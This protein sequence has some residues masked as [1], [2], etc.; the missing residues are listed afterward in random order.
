MSPKLNSHLSHRASRASLPAGF[1]REKCSCRA[2]TTYLSEDLKDFPSRKRNWN[3]NANPGMRKG[4][5]ITMWCYHIIVLL[6]MSC[7]VSLNTFFTKDVNCE[8]VIQRSA[9]VIFSIFV[10]WSTNQLE[11]FLC[12]LLF[13]GTFDMSRFLTMSD[14]LSMSSS[15]L[16]WKSLFFHALL[17]SVSTTDMSFPGGQPASLRWCPVTGNFGMSQV[18]SSLASSGS[19]RN[20]RVSQAQSRAWSC[21]DFV[22][23][24][25]SLKGLSLPQTLSSLWSKFRWLMTKSPRSLSNPDIFK[26]LCSVIISSV[27]LRR[28]DNSVM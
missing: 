27:E 11:F 28:E 24:M 22:S 7:I 15:G 26:R 13:D 6:I 4:F 19:R 3:E 17:N 21:L 20:L 16:I 23:T 8:R 12:F 10:I 18:L 25:R 9:L 2:G 14:N 5:L 1:G